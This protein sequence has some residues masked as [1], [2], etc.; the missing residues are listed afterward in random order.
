MDANVHSVQD[1]G[2][3]V[4]ARRKELGLTQRDLAEYCGCGVR[5]ISDLEGG[6]PTVEMGKAIVVINTLSLD[7]RIVGRG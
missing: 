3:F 1:I 5:F 6:K 7:V 2:L 4:R